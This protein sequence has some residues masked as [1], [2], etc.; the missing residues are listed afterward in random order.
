MMV[1]M[2]TITLALPLLNRSH[3]NRLRGVDFPTPLFIK[4]DNMNSVLST[5]SYV[6]IGTSHSLC[7]DYAVSSPRA[8]IV[9]DGCSS[10]NNTDFGAQVL[11]RCCLSNIER[12]PEI[13][14]HT[15]RWSIR[16]SIYSAE[17]IVKAMNLNVSCLD[18]T[19]VAAVVCGSE[20]KFFMAG[21]GAIAWKKKGE[22][23][24]WMV[25]DF[26]SGAPKYL[27]YLLE[28]DRYA[29]YMSTFG[30]KKIF[31]GDL[32]LIIDREDD[33]ESPVVMEFAP[34]QIDDLEW[35]AVMSDGVE[36]FH[37]LEANNVLSQMT[38]YKKLGGPFVQRRVKNFLRGKDSK[39]SD[40]VSCAAM[41]FGEPKQ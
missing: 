6:S 29:S 9:C 13:N 27:S 15:A 39:H 25:V 18:A 2:M 19:L 1:R 16:D 38:S 7:E 14:I 21:D 35:V 11:A 5:D 8:I 28:P 17:G 26:E 30:D 20:I 37:S 32:D 41:C 33:Y 4:V 34:L 40:D 36:S 24:K 22:D 12:Y 31:K 3:S 10:S 23:A